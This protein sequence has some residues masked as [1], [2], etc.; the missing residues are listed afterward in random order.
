MTISKEQALEAPD[1][2][3]GMLAPATRFERNAAVVRDLIEQQAARIAELERTHAAAQALADKMPKG[4]G[5]RYH[6][7][8]RQ[9][10]TLREALEQSSGEPVIAERPAVPQGEVASCTQCGRITTAHSIE[11]HRCW[12]CVHG[13]DPQQ[14]A[15]PEGFRTS[16]GGAQWPKVGHRYLIRLN[17]V[18]Q[19]EVFQFDQGDD[20][21]GGGEHFWSRGDLDECPAFNPERDEWLPLDAVD[22][23][24]LSAQQP[25]CSQAQPLIARP[26]AEW[27]EEDGPVTWWAWCGHEWAGEPAW[28]GT[29]LDSDWP[30]YHTH[31]TPHPTMPSAQQ[32]AQPE[33]CGDPSDCWEPCGELGK[34]EAHVRVADFSLGDSERIRAGIDDLSK[35][36]RAGAA[37][38]AGMVVG[39]TSG[40]TPYQQRVAA[41]MQECFGPVISADRVERNHR[42]LEE[43]LELVQSMDCTADEAHALVRYVFGRSAGEPAQEVGGVRVTLSA[44]CNAAGIDEQGAAEAEL[45]RISEPE[46]MARIAEKQRNKPAMSPLPGAYPE[47]LCKGSVA[48]GTGCRKCSRCRAEMDRAADGEGRA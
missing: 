5:L 7:A 8:G 14:P 3:V 6:F 24:L 20:G 47:R 42:F 17:G 39:S 48:L 29:P 26:L 32:P 38:A 21:M 46:M 9:V 11:T 2:I 19:H 45:A 25:L 1:A 12:D 40:Q 4:D 27:H 37:Q 16:A 31:W 43:S 13:D 22:C 10:I 34:S 30:G 33:C 36:E 44:L 28:C 18:L 15:V 35:R 23:A 41:W